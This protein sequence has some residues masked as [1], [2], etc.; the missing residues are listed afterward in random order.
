VRESTLASYRWLTRTYVLPPTSDP[1]S[2]LGCGLLTCDRSSTGR[3]GS[4]SVALSK[5][6]TSVRPGAARRRP[7]AAHGRR[8]SAAARSFPTAQ[9]GMHTGLSALPSK[10]RS[11]MTS[12]RQNPAK[13]LRISHWYRPKFT[14]WSAEAARRFLVAVR[15]DRLFTLYA[16]ALGLGL[17]RGELLA[18]VWVDVDL[19]DNVVTVARTLQRIGSRRTGQTAG[20]PSLIR[21]L[22]CSGNNGHGNGKSRRA[23]VSG[24]RTKASSS[25]PSSGRRSSRGT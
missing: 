16:I 19:V 22:R 24:G 2:W 10:T 4:V 20:S 7:D 11:L 1:G 18:L 25:Q 21:S 5:R 12:L 15:E 13:N 17:R 8:E 6:M 3:R 14:P 23:P 9:C